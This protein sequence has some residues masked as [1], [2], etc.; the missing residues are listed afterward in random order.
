MFQVYCLPT[1]LPYNNRMVLFVLN[2]SRGE[3][4]SKTITAI[5]VLAI[6]WAMLP[7]PVIGDD[8]SIIR[9]SEHR[10]LFLDDSLIA[11]RHHVVRTVH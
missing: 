8:A 4:E 3:R 5:G 1:P 6:C 11:I 7:L 10:Q 2:A 9:L